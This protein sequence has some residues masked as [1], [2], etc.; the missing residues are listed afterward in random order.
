MAAEHCD[1]RVCLYYHLVIDKTILH[2]Y[3]D[4]LYASIRPDTGQ[5]TKHQA[6]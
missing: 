4:Q 6:I 2:L 5:G 1:D 3:N